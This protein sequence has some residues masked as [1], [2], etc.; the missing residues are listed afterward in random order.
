MKAFGR[1]ELQAE[2][3]LID[4]ENDADITIDISE[5]VMD[6]AK[7]VLGYDDDSDAYYLASGFA[8]YKSLLKFDGFM[9]H[10]SAVCIDENAYL[11]SGQSGI[12]KSTHTKL[13]LDLLKERCFILNDDKPAIRFSQSG[14]INV[15][16]T[17][18]SG[19]QDLNKNVKAPLKGICFISRSE[20]NK[21]ELLSKKMAAVHIINQFT[22]N[23]TKA[24]WEKV[25]S[26]IDVLVENVPVY[27][28]YCNKDIS[29]AKLSFEN[30]TGE[31]L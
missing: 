23:F 9:L 29:A 5:Q 25:L 16:G 24:Q 28:L 31:K 1:T 17:P 4:F 21:I 12:G 11:F 8:F 6:K 14:G 13:L 20:T 30:L 19:K 18:W 27:K 3:Y 10:S 22:N 26:M 15:Y 7:E 2:K